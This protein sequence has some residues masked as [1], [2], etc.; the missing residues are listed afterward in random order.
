[1]GQYQFELAH[2]ADDR[3]LRRILAAT[4]MPGKVSV[5]FRREPSFYDAAAIDGSF[6]QVI[7][8]RHNESQQI[9]GFGRVPSE[10]GTSMA[11]PSRSGIS[12]CCV[13]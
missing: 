10:K 3:E 1:M 2:P 4:P 5:T 13:P 11:G 12:A 6:R 8:C 9:I 7:V